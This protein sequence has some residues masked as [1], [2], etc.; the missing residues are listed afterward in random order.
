M[1]PHDGEKRREC[2]GHDGAGGGTHESHEEGGPQFAE[3]RPGG[4]SHE[5][6]TVTLET[7]PDRLPNDMRRR[8]RDDRPD[9]DEKCH[10]YRIHREADDHQNADHPA[11]LQIDLADSEWQAS[12]GVKASWLGNWRCVHNSSKASAVDTGSS[13]S[14]VSEHNV[15]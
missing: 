3:R 14:S 2:P 4:C 6:T 13:K 15:W 11:I 5:C 10:R 8:R 9:D 1:A 7:M 12:R